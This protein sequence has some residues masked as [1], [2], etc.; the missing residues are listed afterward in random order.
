MSDT[1]GKKNNATKTRKTTTPDK[2]RSVTARDALNPTL[3]SAE[4]L[5]DRFKT[6]SV[7]TET[8][9]KDLID[10]ANAGAEAA[11][12]TPGQ[13]GA[14]SGMRLSETGQLEPNLESHDFTANGSDFCPGIVNTTTNEIGIDLYNGL[15]YVAEHG[16]DIKQGNGVTVDANGVSVKPGKGI[17]VDTN[18][19]NV[20]AGN[21]VTVDTNGIN[22][23]A[24]EGVSID[25]SGINIK[26]K[27]NTGLHIDS[28]G[29]LEP[30][31]IDYHDFRNDTAGRSPVMVDSYTNKIVVDLYQGLKHLEGHG[32]TLNIKADTGMG[33]DEHGALCFRHIGDI[34]LPYNTYAYF[35]PVSYS[36]YFEQIGLKLGPG[37]TYNEYGLDIYRR[38]GSGIEV[39]EDGVKV[40]L[41]PSGELAINENGEL[42][43]KKTPA[44]EAMFT[45][46]QFQ[47]GMIM[48][49]NGSELPE[50]WALCDGKNNTPDL[51][52]M[53]ISTRQETTNESDA[54]RLED[55]QMVY[56]IKQ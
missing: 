12:Q 37:L 23:K 13:T 47:P 55:Y 21:G 9:F 18:G 33:F 44:L 30:T 56:M 36:N 32:L 4:D 3:P 17:I 49:F 53:F 41:S 24:G 35:A 52:T 34:D 54:I 50:G 27:A 48:A 15:E 38:E 6:G 19:V 11:G 43:L 8:D 51:R 29:Y 14:G 10:L 40:K 28:N 45:G 16:L 42:H 5:K 20:K 7:P 1:A 22:V 39:D 26:L 25:S 31:G 46:A 2:T